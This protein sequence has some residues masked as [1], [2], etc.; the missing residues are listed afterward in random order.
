MCIPCFSKIVVF[1]FYGLLLLVLNTQNLIFAISRLSRTSV[2]WIKFSITNGF[3][4]RILHDNMG[5]HMYVFG[6]FTLI[7][8]FDSQI[9]RSW[10]FYTYN[11]S[12]DPLTL[13][14]CHNFHVWHQTNCLLNHIPQLMKVYSGVPKSEEYKLCIRV[15]RS[16]YQVTKLTSYLCKLPDN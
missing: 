5:R 14:Y 4:I 15:F 12:F 2:G 10:P 16:S 3:L 11:S 6:L 8:T 1:C 9:Y 7:M 13:F